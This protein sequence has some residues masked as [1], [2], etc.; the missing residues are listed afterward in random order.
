ME[1]YQYQGRNLSINVPR[2]GKVAVKGGDVLALKQEGKL[3]HF[4]VNGDAGK[5]F[6][7]SPANGAR[8]LSQ[9]QQLDEDGRAVADPKKKFRDY[10]LSVRPFLF[11][12]LRVAMPKIAAR[13]R[14]DR[15]TWKTVQAFGSTYMIDMPLTVRDDDEYKVTC[16]II[17]AERCF[18]LVWFFPRS[19]RNP[20]YK[21]RQPIYQ[22]FEEL[23]RDMV[24]VVNKRFGQGMMMNNEWK[25]IPDVNLRRLLKGNEG[26]LVW[27]KTS[28]VGEGR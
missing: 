2:K 23:F 7:L 8:L 28:D 6:A 4:A 21:L 27:N 15:S 11:E 9:A 1:F 25:L 13:W 3:W 14:Q 18:Y 17:L 12:W 16:R 10:L 22:D 19:I 26:T 5:V 24:D 20:V